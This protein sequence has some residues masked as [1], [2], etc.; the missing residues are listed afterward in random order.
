MQHL[1]Q[2]KFAFAEI[3]SCLVKKTMLLGLRFKP[4]RKVTGIDTKVL[5][6]KGFMR[7]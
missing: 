1:I 4:Q 2:A 6:Q 3:A 7:E 5:S